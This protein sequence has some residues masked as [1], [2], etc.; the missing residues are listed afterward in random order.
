MPAD[1][2][3][4]LRALRRAPAFT[5]A[6]VLTLSLGLGATTALFTAVRGVLLRPLPYPHPEQLVRLHE[7]GASGGRSP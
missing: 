5:L 6:T 7:V 3:L 1:L 4:A 2:R